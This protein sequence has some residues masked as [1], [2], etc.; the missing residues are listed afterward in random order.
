V[1]FFLFLESTPWGTGVLRC[2]GGSRK[3]LHLSY[4]FDELAVLY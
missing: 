4:R 2:G 1:L 3:Y